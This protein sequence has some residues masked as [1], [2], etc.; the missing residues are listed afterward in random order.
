MERAVVLIGVRRSGNLPELQAVGQGIEAMRGWAVQQ[1][2]PTEL[3]TTLSDIDNQPVC[4]R[5]IFQAVRA[6][7]DRGTVEQLVVY[8]SG[9]GIFHNSS[10]YWLLSEAPENGNEAVNV[11]LSRRH[12]ERCGIPHVVLIGDACRTP[13]SGFLHSQVTGGTSFPNRPPGLHRTSVDVF[14]ACRPGEAASEVADTA[15]QT[16]AGYRA[17]YTDVL[18]DALQGRYPSVL[19]RETDMEAAVARLLGN[20]LDAESHVT[21]VRPHRLRDELPLLLSQRISQ[22]KA[23]HSVTQWPDGHVTSPQDAWLSR[24]EL[25]PAGP[26]APPPPL[27]QPGGGTGGQYER[28][29]ALESRPR[30]S[31]R[32]PAPSASA[33]AAIRLSEQRL[34]SEAARD[35]GAVL[36]VV[37]SRVGA[38]YTAVGRQKQAEANIVRMPRELMK[39]E[40]G[41]VVLADGRSTVIPLFPGLVGKLTVEQDRIA[42]L[43]YSSLSTPEDPRYS[44]F[45]AEIAAASR[46]GIA[47]WEYASPEALFDRF[48][49]QGA[50][51]P[52]LAVY[53]AYALADMGH[54]DAVPSLLGLHP[55]LT[56]FLPDPWLV[57]GEQPPPTTI[58]MPLLTRGWA[59]LDPPGPEQGLPVPDPSHWT[60]FPAA[61]LPRL[62]RLLIRKA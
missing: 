42:D 18:A 51:D 52:S 40:P 43:G 29:V 36:E 14:Y 6:Y 53:L 3:I 34:A 39:P 38:V 57:L 12:A 16:G 30:F 2:I 27:P 44:S 25:P 21:L 15:A 35:A 17:V 58:P 60:L 56:R 10:E 8:F 4:L 22:L 45:R 9:H 62:R 23:L 47:W 19:E 5:D 59:Q 48:V 1:G 24:F 41:V 13:P 55:H 33:S 32:D 37:G 11:D 49:E 54:R 50:R 31:Q 61:E 28:I 26:P 46:F 7:A 20:S